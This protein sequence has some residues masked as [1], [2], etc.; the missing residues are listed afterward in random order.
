MSGWVSYGVLHCQFLKKG[1]AQPGGCKPLPVKFVF[2][3]VSADQSTV[4]QEGLA[5]I[6][7]H[8]SVQEKVL[9]GA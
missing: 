4:P 1:T 8:Q 3:F 2:C 6:Q 9:P 5:T 7:N